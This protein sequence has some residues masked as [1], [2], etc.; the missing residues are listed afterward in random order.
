MILVVLIRRYL[1]YI[2]FITFPL[3]HWLRERPSVLRYPYIAC[4]AKTS[5]KSAEFF[6]GS[7]LCSDQHAV[8]CMNHLTACYFC[9]LLL[10]FTTTSN[11]ICLCRDVDRDSSVGIRNS[12]RAGRSW[13]P[14]PVGARFYRTL[15]NRPWGPTNLLYN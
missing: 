9:S 4:I 10:T 12:L 13:D 11:C 7:L 5:T 3:Q 1:Q 6:I 8:W 15:P 2:I 14:I